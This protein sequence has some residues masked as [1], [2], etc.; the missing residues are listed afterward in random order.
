MLTESRTG[1][2]ECRS[3]GARASH[4]GQE[5]LGAKQ[6]GHCV[7]PKKVATSRQIRCGVRGDG[8]K[9]CF[10]AGNAAR[11]HIASASGL[12][13]ASGCW[14]AKKLIVHSFFCSRQ[15]SVNR[16]VIALHSMIG[17]THLLIYI[18]QDKR[19]S[20]IYIMQA[21]AALLCCQCRMAAVVGRGCTPGSAAVPVVWAVRTPVG[22]RM[23]VACSTE[24]DA[25]TAMH[26]GTA[27]VARARQQG[28]QH[29][30]STP[31]ACN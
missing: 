4:L 8:A 15:T 6:G 24:N 21:V 5:G 16:D 1:S 18:I 23:H 17:I 31:R 29:L 22:P 28:I 25:A 27:A 26:A 13:A 30:Q 19:T 9:C 12:V 14:K 20:G 2:R 7:L 11:A 3:L 10:V